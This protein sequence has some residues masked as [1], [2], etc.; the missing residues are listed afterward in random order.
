MSFFCYRIK[1]CKTQEL[2]SIAFS[3]AVQKMQDFERLLI[4]LELVYC[5]NH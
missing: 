2:N 5:Y 4:L 3:L 1:Y